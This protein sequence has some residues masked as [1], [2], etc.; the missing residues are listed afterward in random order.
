MGYSTDDC[1]ALLDRD[2]QTKGTNQGPWK[3]LSKRNG[4]EGVER[5]FSDKAGQRFVLVVETAQGL[6]VQA[7]A[8]SLEQLGQGSSAKTAKGAEQPAD[9]FVETDAKLVAYADQVVQNLVA[10]EDVDEGS[11]PF[12]K[13]H[14]AIAN[15]F[16]FGVDSTEGETVLVTFVPDIGAD[17]E[18]DVEGVPD[19]RLP[20]DDIVPNPEMSESPN[21][22]G[23]WFIGG[24]DGDIK[25]CVQALVQAGF[26][27]DERV[28]GLASD[29]QGTAWVAEWVKGGLLGGQA[30]LQQVQQRESAMTAE[31][32]PK[33]ATIAE[34]QALLKNQTQSLMTLTLDPQQ[35]TDA[36]FWGQLGKLGRGCGFEVRLIEPGTEL[37]KAQEQIEGHLPTGKWRKALFI[38]GERVK[39][40]VE[41][42]LTALF[43]DLVV[44]HSKAPA[45]AR[46]R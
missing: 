29:P 23:H 30:Q 20:I 8:G 2:E 7:T 12:I 26:R 45:R 40:D 19:Y 3:R 13:A 33:L 43:D 25:A 24:F 11:R 44:R 34:L 1:K 36:A 15:R 18:G 5:I 35:I 39:Q 37:A 4:A 22:S 42:M 41:E 46:P 31:V 6:K 9:R 14:R 10:Y 17:G 38:R 28:Q 21:E 32:F 27:W 16:L